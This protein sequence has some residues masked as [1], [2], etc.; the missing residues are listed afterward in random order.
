[1][2]SNNSKNDLKIIC[3]KKILEPNVVKNVYSTKKR[4]VDRYL[5][6]FI[7][8]EPYIPHE[9]MVER[10]SGST[11]SSSNMHEVIDE[12]SN[13]YRNIIIDV[14]GMNQ[15]YVGQ[16]LIVDEESNVDTATMGAQITINYQSL[17]KCSASSQII[18][19]VRSVTKLLN[20]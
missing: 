11:F 14:M 5:C 4:F 6:W 3:K 20:R 13:P 9:T 10:I 19:L 17:H 15:S 7:H 16:C 1:M 2:A 18:G 12:N 8:R